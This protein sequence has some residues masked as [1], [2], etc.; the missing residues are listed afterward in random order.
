MAELF[1]NIN[2]KNSRTVESGLKFIIDGS[3]APGVLF[4][5]EAME[6]K[7]AIYFDGEYLIFVR[8][9]L[10][11]VFVIA[12]TSQKNNQLIIEQ[13]IG[14]F[15]E[16]E[17]EA[18]K[19]FFKLSSY[20]PCSGR[21]WLRLLCLKPSYPIH[22]RQDFGHFRVME[23]KAYVGT[24]DENLLPLQKVFSAP[25]LYCILLLHNPTYRKLKFRSI[26]GQISI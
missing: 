15:T 5:P 14:E 8:S 7:W 9:W 13:I 10:R 6:H 20:K 19:C 22:T 11:E 4:K 16:G 24:F 2:P 12:K 26:M 3:L 18:Y 21:N 25:T 1:W 23:N 17:T